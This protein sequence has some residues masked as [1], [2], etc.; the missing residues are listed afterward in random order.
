MAALA[1]HTNATVYA[2]DK[3]QRYL[4]GLD[5]RHGH[6]DFESWEGTLL[7]FLPGGQEPK[8]VGD[9]PW[10]YAVPIQRGGS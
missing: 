2:A 4:T 1:I 5:Q 6:V 10:K 9:T 7:R 3:I 8:P